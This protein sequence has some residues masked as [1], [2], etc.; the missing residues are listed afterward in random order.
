MREYMLVQS[1]GISSWLSMR[2]GVVLKIGL[3]LNASAF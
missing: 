1:S 3:S 2:V